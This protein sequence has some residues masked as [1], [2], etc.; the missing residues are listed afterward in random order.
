MCSACGTWSS[1]HWL[2]V[3]M[4]FAKS[5]AIEVVLGS[6]LDTMKSLHTWPTVVSA[7]LVN[8]NFNYIPFNMVF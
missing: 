2:A 1:H 7:V 8:Y 4:D 5:K 3:A 6:R